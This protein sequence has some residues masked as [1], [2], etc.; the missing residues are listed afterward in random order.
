LSAPNEK[1]L[2]GAVARK[3]MT[4][5]EIS[6]RAEGAKAR[7]QII[8]PAGTICHVE[9]LPIRFESDVPVEGDPEELAALHCRLYPPKEPQ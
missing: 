1:E 3:G 7:A 2:S 4:M 5:S 6:E 8:I 9:G